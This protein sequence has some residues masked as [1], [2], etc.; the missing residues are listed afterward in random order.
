[1]SINLLKYLPNKAKPLVVAGGIILAPPILL[2]AVDV[3]TDVFNPHR[4]HTQKEL[5]GI[6]AEEMVNAGLEGSDIRARLVKGRT[7]GRVVESW[8]KERL[9][10]EVGGRYA[11]RKTVR[12]EL[13][14]IKN[15]HSPPSVKGFKEKLNYYFIETPRSILYS[16][17][18][19]I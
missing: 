19:D 6:L 12:H 14:D 16:L 11:T 13:S 10:V 8:D 4:I 17:G 15:D 2:G 9:I 3:A 7:I 5:S 18:F 1:M